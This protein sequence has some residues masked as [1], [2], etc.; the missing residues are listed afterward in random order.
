MKFSPVWRVWAAALGIGVLGGG[1]G[2]RAYAQAPLSQPAPSGESPEWVFNVAPYVWLPSIGSTL[3]YRRHS[4]KV[5]AGPVDYF[6]DLRL[7]A[8]GSADVRRGPFSL[9]TDLMYVYG[10]EKGTLTRPFEVSGEGGTL[11]S[12]SARLATT[13]KLTSTTWTLAGGYTAWEGPWGTLDVLAG[14]RYANMTARLNYTLV[15]AVPDEGSIAPSGARKDSMTFWDA[16]AGLRGRLRLPGS[17]FFIPYYLD[18]GGGSGLTWQVSSGVGYQME[19]GNVAVLY[20]YL[21]FRQGGSALVHR[22][23]LSGPQIQAGFTF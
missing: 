19:W 11:V 10:R 22:Y 3:H 17:G 21:T 15:L 7:A 14:L 23:S 12:G 4:T 1:A 18:G 9:F 20:R 16:I 13:T 5:S 2:S 8:M 6:P